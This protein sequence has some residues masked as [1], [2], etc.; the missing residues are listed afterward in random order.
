[1]WVGGNVTE[2][3]SRVCVT[4][5]IR[6]ILYEEIFQWQRDWIKEDL[7]MEARSG[8]SQPFLEDHPANVDQQNQVWSWVGLEVSFWDP[9]TFLRTPSPHFCHMSNI[10][11]EI[12]WVFCFVLVI[13]EFEF[14]ALCLVEKKYLENQIRIQI[15]IY[16]WVDINDTVLLGMSIP[17]P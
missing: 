15:G 6:W 3:K 7:K 17:L 8:E 11:E 1:M 16:V 4:S 12:L 14:R 2:R 13:L 9:S 10:V 5:G